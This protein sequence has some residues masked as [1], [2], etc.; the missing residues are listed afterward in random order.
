[1]A[2]LPVRDPVRDD[3][4]PPLLCRTRQAGG[5]RIKSG[6]TGTGGDSFL[7]MPDLIRHP[8]AFPRGKKVALLIS[9]IISGT[10]V[11]GDSPMTV[12]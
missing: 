11:A 4:H 3:P 7:V 10:G 1:M 2:V 6:V 8:P 5:P 12:R 9:R